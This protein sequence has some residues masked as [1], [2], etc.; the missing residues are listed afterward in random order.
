[1]SYA[2]VARGRTDARGQANFPALGFGGATVL[3]QAQGFG[4]RRLA[5][6][7]GQKELKVELEP[8]AVYAGDVHDAAGKPVEIFSVNLTANGDQI[9]TSVGPDAR[10]RFRLDGLPAGKWKIVIR[11]EDWFSILYEGTVTLGTGET[12]DL[13]IQGTRPANHVE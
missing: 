7:D 4:R 2:Y 8:E 3:V 5:W 11:A 1:L 6:R 12:R 10:G 9:I 13:S